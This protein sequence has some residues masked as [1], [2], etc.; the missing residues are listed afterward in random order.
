[1][2]HGDS[3]EDMLKSINE[4]VAFWIEIARE[5]GQPLPAP[6]SRKLMLA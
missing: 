6:K 5:T 3:H 2:A 1:M 4:A